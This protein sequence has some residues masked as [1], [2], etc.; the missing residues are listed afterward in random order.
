MKKFLAI[1]L[2]ALVA[3]CMSTTTS[4]TAGGSPNAAT[5]LLD[6]QL[7]T[8]DGTVFIIGSD[9]TMSGTWR[10]QA[11][12]GTY[13][14]TATEICSDLTAPAPIAGERCSTPVIADDTVV[15]NRRDGSTSPVYTIQG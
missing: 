8:E 15:F 3:G 14:A 12:A 2:I 6:K 11:I 4:E 9:G 5:P 10:G 13:E 7:T 1:S